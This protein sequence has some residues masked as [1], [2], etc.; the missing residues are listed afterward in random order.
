MSTNRLRGSRIT[1]PVTQ[2][3][4]FRGIRSPQPDLHHLG[5]DLRRMAYKTR[6]L[7]LIQGI[8]QKRS[9]SVEGI[10]IRCGAPSTDQRPSQSRT[11]PDSRHHRWPRRKPC[12]LRLTTPLGWHLP[13]LP[14]LVLQSIISIHGGLGARDRRVGLHWCVCRCS[15]QVRRHPVPMCRLGGSSVWGR[16]PA[17]G[18]T[19]IVA[20]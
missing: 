20:S 2:V 19:M 17:M 18:A 7:P 3:R 16:D 9:R 11:P 4:G 12:P 13:L 10:E 14:I 15:A 6:P 8:K 1:N 5:R